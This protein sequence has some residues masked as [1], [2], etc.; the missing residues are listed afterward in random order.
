MR[1]WSL[2]ANIE[3]GG[4]K[5]MPMFSVLNWKGRKE[6]TAAELSKA[7]F[8]EVPEGSHPNGEKRQHVGFLTMDDRESPLTSLTQTALAV[9]TI[10]VRPHG[11]LHGLGT[12]RGARGRRDCGS[13]A[14]A[15]GVGAQVRKKMMD[16]GTTS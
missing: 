14:A 7:T 5:K 4:R 9:E 2:V 6:P 13:P 1:H 12:N 8:I 15:H 10:A 11:V 3:S 16:R